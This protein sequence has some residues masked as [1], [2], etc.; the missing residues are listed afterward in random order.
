MSACIRWLI[1]QGGPDCNIARKYGG[2]SQTQIR[3]RACLSQKLGKDR[4]KHPFYTLNKLLT[5]LYIRHDVIV[6]IMLIV[7]AAATQNM[8]DT[9]THTAQI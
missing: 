1:T 5:E 3:S 7:D 9:R 6:M 2:N 8:A 4:K